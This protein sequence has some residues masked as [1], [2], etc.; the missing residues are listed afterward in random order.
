MERNKAR[1]DSPQI[2]Q[3]LYC[4]GY[5]SLQYMSLAARSKD[6]VGPLLSRGA[7]RQKVALPCLLA[8]RFVS[9]G[10]CPDQYRE[11]SKERKEQL[12]K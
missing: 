3:S 12:G 10:A 8:G 11:R 5:H 4:V 9:F 2:F 6:S 1:G 7:I